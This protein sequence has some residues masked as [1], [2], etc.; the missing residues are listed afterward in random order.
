ME[1]LNPLSHPM[2]SVQ[3]GASSL[4][5]SRLAYGCWRLGG[6]WNP[7]DVTPDREAAGRAAVRAAYD[8]GFTLF[9]H[10]DIYCMG[11]GEKI[12]GQV[13]KEIPGMRARVLIASKCGIR[14]KGDPTPAAPYRYDFSANYIVRSCEQSLQR[15]GV[16]TIDLYQLHRPDYLCDPVEVAEAF[17]HLQKSGKARAFGVSN[18]LPSQFALLQKACP[19]PLVVN[20]VEISLSRLDC[21][22][23]G[24][25]DHCLREQVTP[26]A[27]SPL[28][29]GQ[30]ADTMPI[31][32]RSADHALRIGLREE[33]EFLARER[34][35]TRTV[36][37]L[38]WLLKHPARIVPIVGSIKPDRVREAAQAVDFSLSRE[39]WYRLLEAARGERLP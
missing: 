4:T 22:N 39:E 17:A 28:A 33:L 12:F 5:S 35:T 13:L 27:W 38:A 34:N 11:V 31:D 24:T 6:T 32:L 9:D 2:Q 7:E 36:L 14:K 3:L 20:Q 8:A 29:G 1:S 25:L 26:L 16:E 18:F 30:L 19:M 21:L 10:A 37:A 23:D 15:L